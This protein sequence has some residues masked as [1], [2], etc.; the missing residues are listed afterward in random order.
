MAENAAVPGSRRV[1]RRLR[2][3]MAGSDTAQQRLN[4]VVHIIA[5]E[6]VAEVC[7]IYVM[8]AGEVLEL[9]ATEGLRPEAVH[10]TRLRVGEGLVG[11]IAATARPLALADAQS[12]QDF[13]Y[14]PETGEE[15]YHSLMGVPILRGGR[16][17]GVL[18]VQ[19]RT[20][21]HYDEDEIETLQTIAMILAELVASGELVNPLELR[22]SEAADLLPIRIEGIR[23]HGGV[24]LG[25]AVLHEPRIVIRHVV[26]ENPQ[27][28]QQR[29]RRAVAQ[30]QQAI[31]TMIE[32]NV[33]EAGEP[34]EILESYRMFAADRGWLQRITEAVRSGLTAEAA[35]LRVEDEM[36][37]RLAQASDPY[38]RER[39][40]DLEDLTNRLQHHLAGRAPT[41]DKA[42][43]PDEFIVIARS[44]GPAELL[45]YDRTRLKGL[46]LEEG[47]PTAH[48]AIVAR[49]FDIPVI[50]RADNVLER[51]EAGDTIAIDGDE[52]VVLVRPS[53]DV[54]QAIERRVALRLGEQLRYA[55]LTGLPAESVDGVRVKLLLNS[56]LLIDL[57]FLDETGAEGIGLFR[58]ELQYMLRERFP[59]VD[60]QM[61]LYRRVL[62][63]AGDRPVTFRTLDAGGDKL[64]PYMPESADQNPAMGWRAIRIALDRP[65]LLRQQIRALVRAAA[66]RRLRIMFP[67]IAEVSEF[68][69][70]RAI[71]ELEL[72]RAWRRQDD[73]PPASIEVGV[74]LEVPSL[75]FQLEMLLPRI[76]FLS[77]GTNDLM[78][79]LFACDRG[80]PRL[81]ERYDPLSPPALRALREIVTASTRARVEL[82][83]CGEMAGSPLDAAALVAIGF[84]TLSMSPAS[85]GRVK[86]MVRT[87]DLAA[88]QALLATW[89]ALPTHTLR[90]KLRDFCADRGVAV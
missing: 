28:E 70:A 75:L 88:L 23:I 90:D 46:V 30:M 19:N 3:T 68:D 57:P 80:N 52:A 45:D 82:S 54:Q 60:E 34:R 85:V 36:R 20:L 16:V 44:M 65:S 83:L 12:H 55:A 27:A 76:D 59:T 10:R 86:A 78:Q 6:V 43:L 66:G 50:G 39:L 74:M 47:S 25:A 79:F 67:M 64:L 51:V 37:A 41:A 9:F 14:R 42:A 26:A 2:D 22:P 24:A 58:T 63:H 69:A 8:R 40:T 61:T 84:R 73:L 49:A 62:E 32:L 4:A 38:L 18:V 21:R 71:L 87:L 15:I 31:D 89:E 13:A 35:V 77:V 7:S 33:G 11:V 56:G 72:E 17:L 5:G 29:L 48:V 81:A 1:L 53:E